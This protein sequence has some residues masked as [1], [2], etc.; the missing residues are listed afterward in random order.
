MLWRS[1]RRDRRLGMKPLPQSE[2]REENGA[3]AVTKGME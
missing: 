1:K 3:G 2:V